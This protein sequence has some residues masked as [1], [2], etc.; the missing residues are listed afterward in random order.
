M[1]T[2]QDLIPQQYVDLK[3]EATGCLSQCSFGPNVSI[4]DRVYNKVDDVTKLAA[5]IDFCFGIDTP[6]LI[7]AAIEDISKAFQNTNPEKRIQILT[8]VIQSLNGHRDDGNEDLSSDYSCTTVLAHALVL[9][10]DAYLEIIPR[11]DE[12]IVSALNDANKASRINN[13]GGRSWRVVADAKEAKKDIV[14]AMAALKE[15][16]KCNPT[17]S[18]KSLTELERLVKL[19]NI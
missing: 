12:H 9:R 13:M 8:R 5:I 14:G 16:S 2:I 15:W 19:K 11:L 6:G 17:F 1:Q 3:I 10:A 18:K 4:N 7:M